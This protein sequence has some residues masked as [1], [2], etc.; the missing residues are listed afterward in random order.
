VEHRALHSSRV[1][2]RGPHHIRG[3]LL[4]GR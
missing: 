1:H 4:A 2:V 3:R